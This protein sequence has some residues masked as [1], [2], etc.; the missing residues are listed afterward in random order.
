M[1]LPMLLFTAAITVPITKPVKSISRG[2][3]NDRRCRSRY[4][5]L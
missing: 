4:W 2:S 1:I 5:A 3:Q